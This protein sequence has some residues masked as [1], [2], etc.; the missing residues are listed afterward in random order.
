[1]KELRRKYKGLGKSLTPDILCGNKYYKNEMTV[2]K[3]LVA[4]Q[5]YRG[6]KKFQ[7]VKKLRVEM[8]IRDILQP[9]LL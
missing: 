9:R 5:I 8:R 7:V 4:L 6:W 1:M 3:Y 2:T